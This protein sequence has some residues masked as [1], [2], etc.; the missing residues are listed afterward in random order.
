MPDEDLTGLI[1]SV[2]CVEDDQRTPTFHFPLHVE[3][4]R[5]QEFL[6]GG[7]G[8]FRPAE[9]GQEGTASAE[10]ARNVRL[11][12]LVVHRVSIACPHCALPG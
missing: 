7:S 3:E 9:G 6:K 1:L 5:I 10:P 4:A 11:R 8:M 12:T 2:A